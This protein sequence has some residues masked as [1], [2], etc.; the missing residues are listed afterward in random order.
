MRKSTIAACLVVLV[1]CDD[2]GATGSGG[3]GGEGG[4]GAAPVTST[5]S[6]GVSSSSSTGGGL[7]CDD[8]DPAAECSGAA[9][10]TCT[11]PAGY[12]DPNR[13]GTLCTDIDECAT[14][15]DDCDALA[16]CTNTD[17]G[18]TCECPAGYSD[19]NGDGTL[20][21]NIDECA[22]MSRTCD[23]DVGICA[24]TDGSFTC[25][26]PTGYDDTNGD[27]SLC[28][29]LDE[30]TLG[31]DDCDPLATCGDTPGSFTCTC[32]TG[33]D[34]TNGDGSLCTNLDECT[35]G[36]DT[37]DSVAICADAD[38]GFTC[39]CPAGYDDTNGDGSL[40]A[41]LD[42]CTLGTD[43]CD[44]AATC[45]NTTGS[46]TCACPQGTHDVNGDGTSCEPL[47]VYFS[48]SFQPYVFQVDLDTGEPVGCKEVTAVGATVTGINSMVAHPTTGQVFAVAKISGSER[49]LG[50][51]DIATGVLTSIAPFPSGFRFSSIQWTGD[52]ATLYGV[53]G[54][55]AGA[56]ATPET[57]YSINPATA[58]P[59]L[60][61]TLGNG[62]DGELIA[63]DG[64]G[65]LHHWSGNGAVVYETVQIGAGTTNVA[66]TGP[67]TGEMFGAV[68]WSWHKDANGDP[69][70]VFLIGDIG[71]RL[72][73]LHTN[74]TV[75]EPIAFTQDDP[76]GLV[77][78]RNHNYTVLPSCPL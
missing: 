60:V 49:H 30:C 57:L 35:L 25:T 59:T 44:V 27:G 9:P 43:D 31:T 68:W 51:I 75:S 47:D 10:V 21:S 11:C 13:D 42:E 4:S 53:T 55:G 46:F 45:S 17:G 77:F 32:P 8:C 12:A 52:G 15:A 24:D 20:C 19:P 67:I 71:S 34:D 3:F 38:G 26:C 64:S 63:F 33:Y 39:T 54:N 50:T 65:T 76:R 78:D 58:E 22:R 18:F 61:Q 66:L 73:T 2:E 40:C 48:S 74:G 72:R 36:T 14:D 28:T 70:P 16:A 7:T 5:A 1:A 29:N 41:D 56:P 37:C 23:P 69:D 6:T 62:A